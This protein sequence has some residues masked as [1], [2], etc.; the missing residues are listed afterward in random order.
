MA[1][2]EDDFDCDNL[3]DGG[4]DFVGDDDAEGLADDI[5]DSYLASNIIE[6]YNNDSFYKKGSNYELEIVSKDDDSDFETEITFVFSRVGTTWKITDI[7]IPFLESFAQAFSDF[8]NFEADQEF[9]VEVGEEFE[10]NGKKYSVVEYDTL[11]TIDGAQNF[12]GEDISYTAPD[13]Q[14]FARVL[15]KR[16]D[17]PNAVGFGGPSYDL[18]DS[19]GDKVDVIFGFDD[20]YDDISFLEDNIPEEYKQ[21]EEESDVTTE[22]DGFSFSSQTIYFEYVFFLIDEDQDLSDFD[23]QFEQM[24]GS[25]GT[26]EE[27]VEYGSFRA[28]VNLT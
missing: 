18:I 7:E 5:E 10:A 4:L 22:E 25:S 23:F 17:L 24:S 15:V 21:I 27:T 13:G 9:E 20:G 2:E 26:G 19:D 1:T 12:S 6:A 3:S 28:K 16:E 11:K 14:Q 8:E